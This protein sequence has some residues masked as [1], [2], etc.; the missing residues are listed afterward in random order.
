MKPFLAA[1]NP[2]MYNYIKNIYKAVKS[3]LKTQ[4]RVFFGHCTDHN[5]PNRP[6][7]TKSLHSVLSLWCSGV[8]V[9]WCVSVLVC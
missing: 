1:Y 3:T 5:R 7:P 4:I 8:L 2:K 6:Q 9:Y